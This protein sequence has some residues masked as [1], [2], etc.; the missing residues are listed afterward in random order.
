M[1]EPYPNPDEN[2]IVKWGLENVRFHYPAEHLFVDTRFDM[3]MQIFHKDQFNQATI[4]ESK[5]AAVSI[6]F[7]LDTK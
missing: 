6:F 2:Q 1:T 7:T 5:K 3:E 4:C